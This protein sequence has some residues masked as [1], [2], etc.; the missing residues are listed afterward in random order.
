MMQRCRI[1]QVH[2]GSVAALSLTVTSGIAKHATRSRVGVSSTGLAGDEHAD[3]RVHGGPDK[4]VHIYP[5]AHYEAW[6]RELPGFPDWEGQ[7]GFGENLSVMDL[8]ERGV[9]IGDLWRAGTVDLQ[10]TQGRQPCGKLNL[11]FGVADMAVRVQHTLRAGWYC[12][13]LRS[14]TVAA[15]DLLSLVD[16]PYPR[17]TIAR[18]LALIRDRSCDPV[19]LQQVLALPLTPSWR[20]LFERRMESGRV[21]E[22]SNRMRTP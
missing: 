6:R 21:E 5:F 1:R 8:D 19:V 7:G 9:C 12:R 15:G 16:R 18:L 2:V 10:V 22:W 17:W 4:A 14:G 13:V 20:R 11:R 3:L